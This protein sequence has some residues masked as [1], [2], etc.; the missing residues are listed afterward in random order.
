MGGEHDGKPSRTP[1]RSH[2][3]S[4]RGGT[5]GKTNATPQVGDRS[6]TWDGKPYKGAVFTGEVPWSGETHGDT[7]PLLVAET[8]DVRFPKTIVG[9]TSTR[10]IALR[11][12][13]RRTIPLDA[14]S[15]LRADPFHEFRVVQNGTVIFQPGERRELAI[16]FWPARAARSDQRL[17]LV[18]GFGSAGPDSDI[19][20]SGEGIDVPY[21][22]GQRSGERDVTASS[23]STATEVRIQEQDRDRV[24]VATRA[25]TASGT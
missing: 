17:E 8:R 18:T 22:P 13:D 21:D 12:D 4:R 1:D 15:E 20:V 2:T 16:E 24:G 11:N 19:H 23:S 9:K 14:V 3:S 25:R 10:S 5:P 6:S 7:D